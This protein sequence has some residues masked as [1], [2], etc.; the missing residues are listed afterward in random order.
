M[1]TG[2]T[3]NIV[4]HDTLK[5]MTVELGEVIPTPKLLTGYLGITSMTLRSIKLPVMAK[6]VTKIVDFAV[7]DQPAV[8]NVIMGVTWI[9]AMKAVFSTYHLGIKFPTLN[10]I[11]AIW[12]CQKQL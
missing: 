9:N 6:E 11:A 3:F 5:R 2:S 1:D 12:G 7:V 10:G 8:Y 4:F